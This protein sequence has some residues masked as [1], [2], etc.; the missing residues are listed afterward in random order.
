VERAIPLP[1]IE[2]RKSSVHTE[3]PGRDRSEVAAAIS[4]PERGRRLGEEG[5]A[6]PGSATRATP[7]ARRLHSEE[8]AE[9]ASWASQRAARRSLLGA[10]AAK[11]RD[12]EV[13]EAVS[14]MSHRDRGRRGERIRLLI[15]IRLCV[16]HS[17]VGN[18]PGGEWGS[19]QLPPAAGLNP[20]SALQGEDLNLALHGQLNPLK[21]PESPLDLTQESGLT[22]ADGG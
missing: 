4:A 7:Q 13:A 5:P 16:A 15:L 21:R 18:D 20:M 11:V 6:R 2:G 9:A 8:C 17:S 12:S 22:R 19:S 3:Q 1:R 14:S 10:E